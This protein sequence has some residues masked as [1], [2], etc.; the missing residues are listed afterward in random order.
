MLAEMYGKVGQTEEGLATL[1]EA[2]AAAHSSGERYWEAEL[3][4]LK[5]ELLL[6]LEEAEAE[7]EACFHQAESC[8][9]H[10]IEGS[11]P[12]EREIVGA[13]GGGEPVP[14]VAGAG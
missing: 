11:P 8:F 2:L 1:D 14:S 7:V 3:H 4:R 6:R 9:Q 12:P 10:A 5:G 13:A